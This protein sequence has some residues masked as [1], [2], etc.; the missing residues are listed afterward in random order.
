MVPRSQHSADV[1]GSSASSQTVFRLSPSIICLIS[2]CCQAA[3]QRYLQPGRFAE[4]GTAPRHRADGAAA[5]FARSGSWIRS[6]GLPSRVALSGR[7]AH[8]HLGHRNWRDSLA[9]PEVGRDCRWL[10]QSGREARLAT[11]APRPT[12]PKVPRHRARP[13]SRS[14]G[15]SRCRRVDPGQTAR[16]RRKRSTKAARWSRPAG[17]SARSADLAD[18]ARASPGGRRGVGVG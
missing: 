14:P 16:D 9:R 2:Q 5:G 10:A 13:R 15:G 17:S 11:T 6:A 12:R 8:R 7:V 1:P 4:T 3:G 18:A